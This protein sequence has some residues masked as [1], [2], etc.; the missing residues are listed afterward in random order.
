MKK[1][2][3]L[4]LLMVV[5]VN[6]ATSTWK[7]R[8]SDGDTI[9]VSSDGKIYHS[10]DTIFIDD[11]I[12]SD[13]AL[14]DTIIGRLLGEADS[15]ILADS[16][17]W[18][19]LLDGYSEDYFLD[20]LFWVDGNV[21]FVPLAGD[22]QTYIDAADS[23]YTLVLASGAYT[24]TDTLI[25]NKQLN[26]VGQGSSGFVTTPVTPSHGTLI[27][28]STANMV[29]FQINNDNVRISDLS[30]NLTGAASTG[31]KVANNL[32]GIALNDIDVI[33]SSTGAVKGFDIKGSDVVMR[34]L[35][36]YI[37]STNASSAGAYFWNDNTTTRDAVVDCYNVTGTVVG[38][39]TYAY[40]FACYNINDA[41]TLTLNLS[42][43][44]CK[45]LTGTPLD[46]AVIST[47][48]VTNN[49]T[50][51]AYMCTFDGA[52]YDGYQTGSNV[53]SL[54]GSV[55]VNNLISGTVTY[56]ATMISDAVQTNVIKTDTIK[57]TNNGQVTFPDDAVFDST[58]TA[59]SADIDTV[60]GYLKGEADSAIIADTAHNAKNSLDSNFV[61]ITATYADIDTFTDDTHMDS[62]LTVD[63]GY[64]ANVIAQA[65][66][67]E[68]NIS[69]QL[70]SY[71][72]GIKVEHTRTADIQPAT[73][74]WFGGQFVLNSGTTAWDDVDKASYAIQGVIKGDQWDGS[75]DVNAGRFELQSSGSVR[76]IVYILAN[77]GTAVSSSMLYMPTHISLPNAIQINAQS[78]STITNGIDFVTGAGSQLKYGIDFSGATIDSADIRFSDGTLIS[79]SFSTSKL[80]ATYADIDTFT[81]DVVFD[82]NLIIG[83]DASSASLWFNLRRTMISSGE[84][85]R[86]PYTYAT[87][88]IF[89]N[90][91]FR[92]RFNSTG[93][94]I[95]TPTPNAKLDVIGSAIIDTN[96]TVNEFA[97]IGDSLKIGSGTAITKIIKVGSHLAIILP[98]NDTLWAAKDT[99]GF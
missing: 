70:G 60:T 78:N 16:A 47:S 82:S 26:I 37:T 15:A 95:G 83:T 25:I 29:A 7:V 33:I 81:D 35:T 24:I 48:T 58:I 44:V 31:V 74:G 93:L 87:F 72:H 46:I 38:D 62:S 39:A 30:V 65:Y 1:F 63:G 54:G 79:D 10:G 8:D 23:G 77:T 51:N 90:S 45:A 52:D 76:D 67:S 66:K 12:K 20:T 73:G 34:D 86:F 99:T 36:F 28:S 69:S 41:N 57:P 64:I 17:D 27:T 4:F 5:S 68:Y 94:G 55:M 22:I 75:V 61:K 96:L 14:I 6:A 97:S 32:E 2:I 11:V 49:S 43:S 56:R 50:V 21:V 91:V 92:A 85:I 13:R 40:A 80:I 19:D 59:A 84:D 88:S 71:V 18:A 89:T 3:L 98:G 42:A 53:L 9:F